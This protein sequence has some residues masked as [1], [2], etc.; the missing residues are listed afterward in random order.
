MKTLRGVTYPTDEGVSHMRKIRSRKAKARL[1]S[2]LR[3]SYL[4]VAA[5]IRVPKTWVQ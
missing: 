2:G 4:A 1:V 3:A 5:Y